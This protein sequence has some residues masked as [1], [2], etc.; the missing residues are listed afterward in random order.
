MSYEL[1][2]KHQNNHSTE[3]QRIRRHTGP[4]HFAGAIGDVCLATSAAARQGGLGESARSG[5]LSP[6]VPSSIFANASYLT[7]FVRIRP[8][9][10]ELATTV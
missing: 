1:R 4:V 7:D 2:G 6:S 5:F 10:C 9:R 8:G 3:D